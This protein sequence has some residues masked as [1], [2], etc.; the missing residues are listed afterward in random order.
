LV[1]KRAIISGNQQYPW[2]IAHG[3]WQGQQPSF[4]NPKVFKGV[5]AMTFR[6]LLI[7]FFLLSTA[8]SSSAEI[9]KYRDAN[10]VLRF[11]NNLHEVPIDQREKVDSMHEIETK[12]EPEKDPAK[13]P[14]SDMDMEAEALNSE[15][16]LLDNE[17]AKLE[18]DRKL[19]VEMSEKEKNAEEDAAFR[20][21]IESFNARIKAYD[22]KLKV[23][24][25]KV[26]QYNA[27]VN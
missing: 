3:F 9:Y 19:L 11:T 26:G 14:E 12:T 25:E 6:I 17:Y 5:I 10:G 20:E 23:F 4:H 2:F 15:K 21:Q 1:G 22:E 24:E 16:E 18:E 7:A 27:Q 13:T 8:V